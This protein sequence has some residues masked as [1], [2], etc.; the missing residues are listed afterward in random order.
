MRNI[1]AQRQPLKGPKKVDLPPRTFT[2]MGSLE[3]GLGER[4]HHTSRE[5]FCRGQQ[6]EIEQVGEEKPQAHNKLKTNVNR[7]GLKRTGECGCS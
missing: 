1:R 5:N 2:T 3:T 7:R 6:E 4:T